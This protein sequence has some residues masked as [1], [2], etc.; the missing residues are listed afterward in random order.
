MRKSKS[1]AGWD[2]TRVQR[3]LSHYE[4]Q[5]EAEAMAEDEASAEDPTQTL[6]EVPRHLVPVIRQLIAEHGRTK[7]PAGPR[8]RDRSGGA[9]RAKL[10]AK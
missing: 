5:S 4:Q 3:V 7:R 2:E 6:M 10:R 8:P 9:S 1:P